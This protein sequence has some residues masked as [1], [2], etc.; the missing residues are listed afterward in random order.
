MPFAAR[1]REEKRDIPIA[2][3]GNLDV[4]ELDRADHTV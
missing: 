2:W 3:R 4:L 1:V